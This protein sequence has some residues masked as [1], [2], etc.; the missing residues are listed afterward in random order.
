MY[1]HEHCLPPEVAHAHAACKIQAEG[2]LGSIQ[3]VKLSMQQGSLLS[4]NL[5]V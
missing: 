2:D 1:I 5:Q 4:G 3:Q